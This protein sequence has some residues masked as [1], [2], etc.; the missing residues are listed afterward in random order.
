M[1]TPSLVIVGAPHFFSSTTFR[2]LGPRVT[3]TASASWFIPR[4]RPRLASSSNAIIFAAIGSSPPWR[5]CGSS[6]RPR[7]PAARA[8]VLSCR[9]E[10]PHRSIPPLCWHSRMES[11]STMSSTLIGRVQTPEDFGGRHALMTSAWLAAGTHATVKRWRREGEC[12]GT[13][14]RHG[15][16]NQIGPAPAGPGRLVVPGRSVV[17]RAARATSELRDHDNLVGLRAS[18][19]LRDL[20]LDALSLFEGAV[21]IRL[22]R[23]EMDENV[24]ATVDGDEAVSLVRVKPLDGALSH[25]KQ[26]PKL[27]RASSSAL[28][29]A[30]PVDHNPAS[31]AERA[32]AKTIPVGQRPELTL[33]CA[34]G[35]RRHLPTNHGIRPVFSVVTGAPPA[36]AGMTETRSPAGTGV[37]RPRANRTSSS[38]T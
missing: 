25:S 35:V 31:R 8:A 37:S 6:R 7:R 38:P 12:P 22:D 19:A 2:P 17:P 1:D 18:V 23:G 16:G 10:V 13:P 5:I 9:E 33:P 27:A 21:T 11:A 28:A 3:F 4:S 34:E 29:T 20:E 24:L 32:N 36:T 14:E 30:E 26:L 15:S